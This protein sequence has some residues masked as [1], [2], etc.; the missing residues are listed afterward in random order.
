[1]ILKQQFKVGDRVRV[2]NAG[3]VY[4]AYNRFV[5]AYAPN[6][7]KYWSRNNE[8]ENGAIFKIIT[9]NQHLVEQSEMLAVIYDGKFAFVINIKGLELL[10]SPKSRV[11]LKP[12]YQEITGSYPA[13][14]LIRLGHNVI[15]AECVQIVDE[16]KYYSGTVI[17]AYCEE[18]G[19][20]TEHKAYIV[21]DGCFTGDD[22]RLLGT[23]KSIEDINKAY[24]ASSFFELIEA[25]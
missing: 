11:I 9:L 1:M 16:P 19:L 2:T 25:T 20:F 4:S 5:E 22:G 3:Q 15:P 12:E 17:C 14:G 23:F 13:V 24:S 21:T 8:T 10:P 18:D 6:Y 7:L